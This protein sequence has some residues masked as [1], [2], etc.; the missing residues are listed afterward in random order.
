M[1]LA[2]AVMI[3]LLYSRFLRWAF[4][5][6]YREFAWTYDAV[7]AIV[8]RGLWQHWIVAVLPYLRGRY[9]LEIGSGTGYLQRALHR[10]KIQAV[11]LDVSRQMLRLARRKVARDGAQAVLLQAVGQ[12]LPFADGQ[13]SDVVATFPSEYILEQ[14][15]LG[16]VWRVLEP[17]GQLL[18]IDAAQFNRRDAYTAA[19]DVAY[20]ATQQ[21]RSEDARPRLL[22]AQGF[23]VET[24]WLPVR[25]SHVQL[26][27][28]TKRSE[29]SQG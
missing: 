5:R 18:L 7:A 20:R 17:G 15:T 10:S 3:R 26:L 1:F 8:S 2:T 25:D 24:R 14:A 23:A 6:F 11:G 19:V 4:T 9:V 21:I 13:F 28:A 22:E 12:H 29:L 16:E 27:V